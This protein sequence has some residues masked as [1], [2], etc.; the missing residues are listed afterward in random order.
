MHQRAS[1]VTTDWTPVP[2]DGVARFRKLLTCAD[3][4][5]PIVPAPL[6]HHAEVVI[7]FLAEDGQV[8][9]FP[10]G[11]AAPEGW[12]AAWDAMRLRPGDVLECQPGANS[13][14][15]K[16]VLVVAKTSAAD[17]VAKT[18]ACSSPVAA[19]DPST[20]ACPPAGGGALPLC[21][22]A[23]WVDLEFAVAVLRA[24]DAGMLDVR[25]R[26]HKPQPGVYVIDAL[27]PGALDDQYAW[28]HGSAAFAVSSDPTVVFFTCVSKSALLQKAVFVGGRHALVQYVRRQVPR[29]QQPVI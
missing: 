11:P 7:M 4:D 5:A 12:R 15:G 25:Q 13:L 19:A 27:V 22:E 23:A 9:S 6:R 16:P 17:V 3:R 10:V 18:S 28:T 1:T 21:P 8:L 2:R 14:F 29:R 24:A 20:A 26:L